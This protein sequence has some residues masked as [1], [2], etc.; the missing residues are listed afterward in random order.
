MLDGEFVNDDGL[1]YTKKHTDTE[2]ANGKYNEV[3]R[4][5]SFCPHDSSNPGV[6]ATQGEVQ[7]LASAGKS[8]SATIT[9]SKVSGAESYNIYVD[10]TKVDETIAYTQ[11]LAASVRTDLVGLTK[12]THNVEIAK[13]ANRVIKL[14]DG[15]ISSIRTNFHPLSA[16]DLVW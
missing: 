14:K 12:G 6:V 1:N 2:F 3:Y 4:M 10:G 5:I 11:E 8:E 7:I 16:Q 15:L 13:M 9:Y